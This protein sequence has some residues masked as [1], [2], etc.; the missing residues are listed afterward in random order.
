MKGRPRPPGARGKIKGGYK[1]R[2]PKVT[3]VVNRY[4]YATASATLV[5]DNSPEGNWG[6]K[7]MWLYRSPEGK[8]F[9]VIRF[10]Y[11]GGRDLL[12]P[13]SQ[14]DA[15]CFYIFR[16]HNHRLPFEEAFPQA[17]ED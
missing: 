13:V 2:A 9:T 11:G 1:M 16:L 6:G 17:G 10:L 15:K 14:E 7:V 4:R 8:Y 12:M 3:R 5:A